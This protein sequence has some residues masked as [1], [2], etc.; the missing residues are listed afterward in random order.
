MT[1][2]R[3]VA[4][5]KAKHERRKAEAMV[6]RIASNLATAKSKHVASVNVAAVQVHKF[7]F[8]PNR[9]VVRKGASVTWTVVPVTLLFE[10]NPAHRIVVLG[11]SKGPWSSPEL[12]VG[13]SVSYT[14]DEAGHFEFYCSKFA[15]MSG[16]VIVTEAEEAMTEGSGRDVNIYQIL[17]QGPSNGR[18]QDPVA[19][20]YVMKS[21]KHEHKEEA[22]LVPSL[23]SPQKQCDT[24]EQRNTA[25]DQGLHREGKFNSSVDMQAGESCEGKHC[26]E[27][28]RGSAFLSDTTLDS[29]VCPSDIHSESDSDHDHDHDHER[30]QSSV[31]SK[32]NTLEQPATKTTQA[33]RAFLVHQVEIS[34]E[35]I[36]PDKHVICCGESVK[37]TAAPE[38]RT[39]FT[40]QSATMELSA[41][42]LLPGESY[43]H[44][45][46]CEGIFVILSA[47]SSCTIEVVASRNPSDASPD[48]GHLQAEYQLPGDSALLE[49]WESVLPR[50]TRRK[51]S[52]ALKGHKHLGKKE[53]RAQAVRSSGKPAKTKG[54][55]PADKKRYS[56]SKGS[57]HRDSIAHEAS[58]KTKPF[59]A[60]DVNVA[61]NHSRETLKS[62]SPVFDAAAT[63]QV[64]LLQ[65][66]RIAQAA[67]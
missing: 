1:R 24:K 33:Q 22:V 2:E 30:V 8:V 56:T 52:T 53:P 61:A 28:S 50:R 47:T 60:K 3:M 59:C 13:E 14:F 57:K 66:E 38:R 44:T 29:D 67:M 43:T 55:P 20:K 51:H 39:T 36:T 64:L 63:R 6:A 31:M 19:R 4:R 40:L 34:P 10:E 37:L 62:S 49:G 54:P 12:K 58:A 41:G 48:N 9:I 42:E 25:K 26:D 15:F 16:T 46:S 7:Q 5:L 27:S 21:A 23:T 18:K 32:N 35:T 11:H 45:F 17:D 65:W